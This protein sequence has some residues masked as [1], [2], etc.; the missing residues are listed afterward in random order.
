MMRN[1]V[2]WYTECGEVAFGRV[3]NI[4]GVLERKRSDHEVMGTTGTVREVEGVRRVECQAVRS[5]RARKSSIGIRRFKDEG[6][7]FFSRFADGIGAS[8][9]QNSLE[10]HYR[11]ERIAGAAVRT[12]AKTM[13]REQESGC[14]SEFHHQ[15]C[16]S[17]QNVGGGIAVE[18]LRDGIVWLG[19]TKLGDSI[20]RRRHGVGYSYGE[21][22]AKPCD[23]NSEGKM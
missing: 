11:D 15:V 14:R 20:V 2:V 4:A 12:I 18:R 1:G 6:K 19:D 21:V 17:R 7:P 23:R 16:A 22:I 8:G 3:H 5:E 9:V 10:E 13:H